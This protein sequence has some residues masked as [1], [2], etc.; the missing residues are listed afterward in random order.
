[1]DTLASRIEIEQ[2][3]H[4]EP[5]SSLAGD[6]LAELANHTQIQQLEAGTYVFREGDSDRQAVYLLSGSVRLNNR[7]GSEQRTVTG[8]TP[9][10][11]YPLAREIPR[12]STAVA[13]TDVEVIRI[14][15]DLLDTLLAWGQIAY[16]ET[17][18]IMSQ[19][20]VM[21]IDKGNWLKKML[22]SPTFNKLPPANVEQLLD[23]LEPI[24]VRAG[25]VIIKQGDVG[26]YFYMI[27]EGIALVSRQ[28]DEEGDNMELAELKAG[29]SFGESALISNKPRNATITMMSDGVLLR[30]SKEDFIKLLQQP[31]LRWVSFD[32]AQQQVENGGRW[33]DVRLPSEFSHAHLNHADNLPMGDLHK[34]SKDLDHAPTYICY[35][36]SG[37]RSSAA[38]FVLSQYGFKACV[39]K[40]GIQSVPDGQLITA[41]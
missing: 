19:D 30:L 31:T 17:E 39:L 20:G 5:L 11:R 24:K 26:D 22:T 29:D 10:G 13:T 23:R 40:D 8:G 16:P 37:R 28:L 9:E 7:D 4:L 15:N 12:R 18:V 27:N 3:Q 38:A 35:C 32:Q 14:D 36:D 25:E 2:L 6:Q 33:L 1:M 21:T 34:K 41:A